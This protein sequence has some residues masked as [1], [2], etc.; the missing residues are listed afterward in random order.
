M[1]L[2]IIVFVVCINSEE[3]SN[4]IY[5]SGYKKLHGRVQNYMEDPVCD[6]LG[7]PPKNRCS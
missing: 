5:I 7:P 4:Y 6:E 3:F 2:I 1:I